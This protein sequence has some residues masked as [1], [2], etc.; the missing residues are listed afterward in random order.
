MKALLGIAIVVALIAGVWKIWDYWD[1]VNKERAATQKQAESVANAYYEGM[2]Q[3]LESSLKKAQD[4]GPQTFKQ[5]LDMYRPSIKDPRLAAIE[6]DYVMAIARENPVEAKRVFLQVK[7]R[8]P[9]NAPLHQRI[10]AL[11]KNYE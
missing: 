10:Q 9:T 1:R 4:S 3:Q 7:N 2:P 8:V 6:L 11:E 5:W